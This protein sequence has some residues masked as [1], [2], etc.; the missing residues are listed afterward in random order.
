MNTAKLMSARLSIRWVLLGGHLLACSSGGNASSSA[1]ASGGTPSVG[2]TA[3]GAVG[4]LLDSSGTISGDVGGSTGLS[5]LA[6][7]TGGAPPEVTRDSVGDLAFETYCSFLKRCEPKLGPSYPTRDRC[8]E[9]MRL[10]GDGFEHPLFWARGTNL[11]QLDEMKAQVCLSKLAGAECNDGLPLWESHESCTGGSESSFFG[12]Q[13]LHLLESIPECREAV[14][15]VLGQGACCDFRGGCSSGLFCEQANF[16]DTGTCQLAGA[17]GEACWTR[18]CQP[19]LVCIKSVCTPQAQFG[20]PCVINNVFGT[21]FILSNCGEGLYCDDSQQPLRCVTADKGVGATCE[22]LE[23]AAGLYC[24]TNRNPAA[25]QAYK[26]ENETCANTDKCAEGLECMK[27]TCRKVASLVIGEQ[28]HGSAHECAEGVEGAN[29]VD[30]GTGVLRC[31]APG[32][33]GEV[34]DPAL[35]TSACA[36]D[37]DLVCDDATHTCRTLPSL[38]QPCQGRCADPVNVFCTGA[39]STNPSGICQARVGL[40]DP[41][42]RKPQ[43][44]DASACTSG[45]CSSSSSSVDSGCRLDLRC[46]TTNGT[47][48]ARARATC[49]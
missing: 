18:P 40:G 42:G 15:G 38:G 14:V 24:A 2:A 29:C 44:V 23:C 7:G 32:L 35:K 45:S 10:G 8:V 46:D 1:I 20:E 22:C 11:Y 41:C 4:G 19:G 43:D 6:P 37:H 31:K 48:V 33:L 47:C 30:D 28:C 36:L 26:Q 49:P 9:Q 21:D 39:S 17:S 12:Y 13:L 3:S 5:T 25:C 34:C 16:A 27:G